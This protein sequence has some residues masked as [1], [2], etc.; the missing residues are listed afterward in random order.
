[1]TAAAQPGITYKPEL[2]C[3]ISVSDF[4]RSVAWY[5]D[6]LG[7]Q[8]VYTLEDRAGAS[9]RPRSPASPS[10]SRRSRWGPTPGALAA[11]C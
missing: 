3:A 10:A 2:I 7:F 4:K 1:M 9:S 5:Q 8:P 6:V 11:L